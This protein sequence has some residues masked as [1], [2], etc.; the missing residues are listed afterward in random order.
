[1]RAMFTVTASLLICAGLLGCDRS[2]PVQASGPVPVAAVPACNCP[3]QA[4][5]A[6]VTTPRKR[7]HHRRVWHGHESASYSESHSPASESSSGSSSS[8]AGEY[9]TTAE[10]GQSADEAQAEG[11]VWIDGYGRSHYETSASA[12]EDDNPGAVAAADVGYRL[13]PWHAYNANCDRVK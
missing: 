11:A 5:A 10:S 3:Q 8:D 4:A 1:M 7:R 2:Q 6:P 9:D 13:A 12:S